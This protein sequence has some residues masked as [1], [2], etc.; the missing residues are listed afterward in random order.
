MTKKEG[1][2][3]DFL[4]ASANIVIERRG[5]ANFENS[6]VATFGARGYF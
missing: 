2:P 4:K 3:I 5:L 6:E 1:I